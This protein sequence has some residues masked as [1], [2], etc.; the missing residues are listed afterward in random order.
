MMKSVRVRANSEDVQRER[1]GTLYRF[2][3]WI[4]GLFNPSLRTVSEERDLLEEDR[5]KTEVDRA[6]SDERASRS[7]LLAGA[8]QLLLDGHSHGTVSAVYGESLTKE[9][10]SRLKTSRVQQATSSGS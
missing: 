10:E 3:K 1:F 2:R 5:L 4:V 7:S 6:F 9:A 8:E